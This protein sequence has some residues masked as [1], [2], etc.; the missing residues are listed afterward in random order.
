[1]KTRFSILIIIPVLLFF[2][3]CGGESVPKEYQHT[4]AGFIIT[5]P[6]GWSKAS[7]D[8]EMY[9]FRSG[10][11]KLIEVGGFDLGVPSEDLYSISLGEFV[12][13]LRESAL[14]GLDGYCDEARI[15]NYMINEAGETRWGGE[16]AYRLQASGYSDE[17]SVSMILDMIVIVEKE[18]SRMYM[19]A[20][21]IEENVYPKVEKDLELMI[22]SF[23][24][25]Q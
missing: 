11:Y 17:A 25:M 3:N 1:M 21:Q 2:I 7:E 23:Q 24:V 9:E 14:D 5:A 18:T 12:S 15:R 19:F 4:R 13:L 22:A 10:N 8:N 6:A 20:S 16:T